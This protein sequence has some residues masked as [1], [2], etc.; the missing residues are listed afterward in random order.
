MRSFI[1]CM[2]VLII[3]VS[4]S[5]ATEKATGTIEGTVTDIETKEPL[6]NITIQLL[7]ANFKGV[8]DE[9]GRFH[10]TN[11]PVGT[12]SLSFSSPEYEGVVKTDIIIRPKRITF[13][14]VEMLMLATR[15]EEEVTVTSD[16]FSK[17]KKAP[18]SVFNISK[19][20]IRRA[21]G[22]YGDIN[23]MVRMLPGAFNITDERNDLIV[24]GGH[25][26]ESGFVVDNIEIPN[27][28]H[29]PSLRSSGGM[30]S[31]LNPDLIQDVD[32]YTGN[33]PSEYG[34]RLSSILSVKLREGNRKEF[35]S[36]IDFNLGAAGGVAE[37]PLFKDK[38]S[39]LV[40]YRKSY[41]Q[42]LNTLKILEFEEAIPQMQDAQAKIVLD[43]NPRHRIS[44][45]DLLGDSGYSHDYNYDSYEYNNT[46]NTLGINWRYLWS[47]KGYSETTASYSYMKNRNY[48]KQGYAGRV[49]E[50]YDSTL[51]ESN[52]ALRNITHFRLV[53]NLKLEFGFKLRHDR[54]IHLHK[55]SY[56]LTQDKER[57]I[58][59][60]NTF[61]GSAI[62][63]NCIWNPITSLSINWGMRY[64]Y[65]TLNKKSHL[66]P[67]LSFKYDI[68]KKLSFHAGYGI[69]YQ[70]I[71][72]LLPVLKWRWDNLEL[73]DSRADHF[74]VGCDFLFNPSAKFTLE[75]YHKEY[76]SLPVSS[77]YP[78]LL[79]IDQ[80]PYESLIIPDEYSFKGKAFSQGIE[81]FFQKKL[82]RN[83]YGIASISLSQSKYKPY[84]GNWHFR[85]YDNRLI[86]NLAAGYRPNSKWE[87]GARF[88]YLS[89][90]PYT[91]FDMEKSVLWN[92]GIIDYSQTNAQRL[93]PYASLNI[94]IDRRFHF[95]SSNLVL[96]LDLWNTFNRKNVYY[97]Y[98]DYQLKD[99]APAN[100]L[101]ILPLFGFE[102]EF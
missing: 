38:G 35:D 100:G 83:F 18:S 54:L 66:S 87:F 47:E 56:F 3:L 2:A 14:D 48:Y 9:K 59:K 74:V 98:W 81:F 43:L 6:K 32:F 70:S 12:Y 61:S 49:I 33:F 45:I 77:E 52:Y 86:V 27:L 63:S 11:V 24:R 10:F 93:P 31:A 44:I 102:F 5:F 25:P 19:E 30:Y 20:E 88:T 65:S 50:S 55:T 15:V 8:S 71:P 22:A 68:N 4:T 91:P 51:T 34:E 89:G 64:E 16:Y 60:K 58:D 40:S 84:S 67:R 90:I 94:R 69:F 41:L 101:P 80:R 13:V 37:G 21:P 23:R 73:P 26:A 85:N 7:G 95:R 62:F 36:Q 28:N 29:F 78:E 79:L 99:K 17:N 75:I 92:Y 82:T 46:Q 72:M 97:Y 53:K 57:V 1:V 42:F 76:R 96:Y 39:W